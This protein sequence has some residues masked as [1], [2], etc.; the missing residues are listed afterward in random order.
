MRITMIDDRREIESAFAAF[1]SGVAAL[2]AEVAGVP[3]GLVSTSFTV[4]VSFDPPQVLF[5]VMKTSRTWPTMRSAARIG[6][7]VLAQGHEAACMQLASRTRDRFAGID[8]VRGEGGALLIADAA[9]WLECSLHAE[10]DSGDHALVILSVESM[11]VAENADPLVYHGRSF[12]SL[13]RS[14]ATENVA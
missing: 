12:R 7:S 10:Y 4:G 9:M 14:D 8:V 5:S 3:L 1:P 6:V 2:T 11:R 13:V